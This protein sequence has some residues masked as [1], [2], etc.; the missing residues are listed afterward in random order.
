M[1]T[2]VIFTKPFQRRNRLAALGLT[3]EILQTAVQYGHSFVVSCTPDHPPTSAGFYGWSEATF[4][5]RQLLA[6]VGWHASNEGNLPFTV[7]PSNKLAI[8]TASGNEFT[9]REDGE[10]PRTRSSK[11]SH[12]K[13]AVRVNLAHTLFGDIRKLPE[14]IEQGNDNGR[15]TWILLV[16]RDIEA[17]EVRSELS[18]PIKMDEIGKVIGWSE[19]VILQ[20][21][22][23]VNDVVKVPDEELPAVGRDRCTNQEKIMIQGFNPT[24]LSLARRLNAVTMSALARIV[25]VEP[26]TISAYEAGEY[27]PSEETLAKIV[28]ALGCPEGFYFG[29]TLDEPHLDSVSFRSLARMT[30]GQRDM[31]RAQGTIALHLNA[32]LESR[33]DLP[34]VDVPDLSN[35]HS[36]EAAAEILRRHWGI[37][38][39]PIRNVVICLNRRALEYF[40]LL[41]QVT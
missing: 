17:S 21:I 10:E 41:P 36:P 12:T 37:G 25:G 29:P 16:Y 11:G 34:V 18:R 30:A 28:S 1:A 13:K 26:R 39:L 15:Q 9:G 40:P 4:K 3:E 31:A 6:P 35:E 38:E 20:P 27:P 24:R 8:M 7:N 23:F 14:V 19:R 33:F 22:P 32:Y 2:A 5:L